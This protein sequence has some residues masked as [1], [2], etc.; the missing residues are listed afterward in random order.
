MSYQGHKISLLKL[1]TWE[2]L[3]EYTSLGLEGQNLR[4]IIEHLFLIKIYFSTAISIYLFDFPK[5][6]LASLSTRNRPLAPTVTQYISN[7]TQSCS[8]PLQ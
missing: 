5:I 6:P 4:L 8:I 3:Q 1:S 2:A 7:K